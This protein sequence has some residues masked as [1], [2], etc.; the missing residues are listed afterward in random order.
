M[1]SLADVHFLSSTHNNSVAV[2]TA[3]RYLQSLILQFLI[4]ATGRFL[5]G[6]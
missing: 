5:S 1:P 2:P 6:L 4:W 3:L